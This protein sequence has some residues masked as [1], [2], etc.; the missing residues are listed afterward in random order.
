M[1]R[2]IAV[3]GNIIVDIVKNVDSYP[4]L[5]MLANIRSLAPA[6][7]GCVP[8]V[9]IDL[10][11]MD[12]ALPVKALGKVGS[13]DYGQLLLKGMAAQNINTAGVIVTSEAPTSF[14]DV[15][16][17]A[18]G[19]RTFFHA[20]GANALFC[21]E[22]IDPAQLHCDL[23]HIGYILL[24]DKFDADDPEYGTAMARFLQQ[25]QKAGI[26]TSID[27]V[28]DSSGDFPKKVIPALPYC[29]YVIINEIECC[30]IWAL[31][32]RKADGSLDV[33]V[34]RRAMDKTLAQGVK[35]KVIVHSKEAGF[36][37]NKDG[38]FT[39]VPSLQIPSQEIKGSVGAGDA[40]CAGC[41]Y[42]I[43]TGL[44]DREMLEFASAA[45]ACNLFA[46]N[47]VDGMR[48]RQQILEVSQT[49]KR[50]S[51]DLS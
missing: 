43:Y 50:Y 8:N 24:L 41:L 39:A 18:G 22:D 11:K 32:P 3:A 47:A 16:S 35:E 26:K 30:S 2:G 9:A 10:K 42:G 44:S 23:L 38:R 36:C 27:A 37:L 4:K 5:G 33:A 1:D 31:E 14:T 49:Y 20:R 28:S 21:P 7:G 25:V 12:P 13:D 29:D 48:S 45:A 51:L 6:I 17:L 46:E 15:M 40:Y 34:L 19:E